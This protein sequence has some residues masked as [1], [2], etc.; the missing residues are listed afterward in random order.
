MS[1]DAAKPPSERLIEC[2]DG[3]CFEQM[4]DP[5]YRGQTTRRVDSWGKVNAVVRLIFHVL[6]EMHAELVR[7]RAGG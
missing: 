2:V 5:R 3:H 1:F 4:Q 7:L 6:D